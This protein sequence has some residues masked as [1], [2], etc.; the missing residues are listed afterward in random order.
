MQAAR[1]RGGRGALDSVGRCPHL[2]P[3]AETFQSSYAKDSERLLRA[4]MVVTEVTAGVSKLFSKGG[5]HRYYLGLFQAPELRIHLPP[6]LVSAFLAATPFIEIGIG[7]G[8]LWTAQRRRF[9][10]AFCVF[11]MALE[12]GHYVMEQ[13][14]AVNEMIPFIILGALVVML[15]SHASWFGRDRE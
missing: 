1:C 3:M 8:L 12:F 4:A 2:V 9:A 13:W 15:P 5:F 6:L 7:L 14:S 11:F 10:A